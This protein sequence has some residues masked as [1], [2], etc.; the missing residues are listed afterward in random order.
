MGGRR[1]YDRLDDD[2]PHAWSLFEQVGELGEL[3][4]CREKNL[5]RNGTRVSSPFIN[6]G[7]PWVS[8][9][10]WGACWGLF[11]DKC[12]ERLEEWRKVEDKKTWAKLFTIVFVLVGI[13]ILGEITTQNLHLRLRATHGGVLCVRRECCGVG[14]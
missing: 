1:R 2:E 13:G 7:E 9:T 6:D 3:D 11:V 14:R 12:E 8:S 10:E 5:L 4:D